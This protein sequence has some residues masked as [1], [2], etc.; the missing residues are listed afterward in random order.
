MNSKSR[1]SLNFTEINVIDV[2]IIGAGPIGLATAL[3]FAKKSYKTILIEQY[4]EIK[5]LNSRVFNGRNQQVG[6]DPNSMNFIRDL[7]VIVWGDV[8]TQGCNQEKWINIPIG[9]L[10]D[11]FFKELKTLPTVKILF[12]TYLESVNCFNQK[13]NARITIVQD[14]KLCAIYPEIIIVADGRHDDKGT[15]RRFFN[16]S[17]ASKVNFSTFGI[18]GIIKRN[19]D[20][21]SICL[22]SYSSDVYSSEIY[23]NLGIMNIR[24]LG[25]MQERYIA[26]GV[27]DAKNIESFKNINSSQIHELLKEA[28]NKMRDKNIGEPE[29]DIFTEYSKNPIPIILDYR[30]ETIK[31]LDGSTS[32]V[33]VEG[34]AA[35]K[36][37]FFSGSGLNSGFRGL[38]KLF[39][40]C[41]ENKDLIFSSIGD[42]NHLLNLDQKLLEKDSESMKISLDLLIKGSTYMTQHN[43]TLVHKTTVHSDDIPEIYK[44][45]PTKGEI[46][47]FINIKGKNFIGN[48]F[49]TPTISFIWNDNVVS[50]DDPIV[51]D[52]NTLG[53]KIPKNIKGKISI[54]VIR[55]DNKIATSP[56]DFKV[57]KITDPPKI[58]DI[59][60][61]HDSLQINGENFIKPINVTIVDSNDIY[62]VKGYC[63]SLQS[64]KC[65]PPHK[66]DGTVSFIVTTKYGS[67][68]PFEMNY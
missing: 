16:F 62:S 5:N 29:V 54:M 56:I 61:D 65:S 33:S 67:S 55:S 59:K 8:K 38:S 12:N 1:L 36:T 18:I 17:P 47:S 3:W 24:L 31:I 4:G 40:F 10:Q 15:A 20:T 66:L 53:V 42:A 30:K 46:S 48:D 39:K 37:T 60:E 45:S 32:I 34:D 21:G 25:S 57:I 28:Y 14:N 2:L 41:K 9:K 35:R 19:D 52:N 27:V 50:V 7:D 64:L 49:K 22:N 58:V 11:I 68:K 44:I 6:I 13:H 23:P 43:N 26:L 51:Y 63:S